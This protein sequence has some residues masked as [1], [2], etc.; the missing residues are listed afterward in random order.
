MH[1]VRTAEIAV[2]PPTAAP[3]S[4]P[5][6]TANP[7]QA[8]AWNGHEGEQWTEHADRYDRAGRR[9]W[10]TLLDRCPVA[11]DD[12]VVDIGCGTGKS[13]RDLA[14]RAHG[15]TVLGVDL[16]A[17]ML[18]LARRRS[19]AEGLGNVTYVQA[20]AQVHPFPQDR[21]DMAISCFGAMF[22]SDPVAAFANIGRGL[23]PGG[24]LV[25][26]AWRDITS[27]EWLTE[28]RSAL[29]VG[30]E[31][32]MPPPEAP[33]PFALADPGRV[34]AILEGS[35]YAGV[36]MEP[37]DEPI[38]FGRDA[39]D[40]Y[41]FMRTLG[42]VKGLTHDLDDRSR[43]EAFAVL[44]RTIAA[45]ETADGVLFGTASWLITAERPGVRQPMTP[46]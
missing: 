36:E 45:H 46:G 9:H 17:P 37:V 13:T 8:A 32:P 41:G 5:I 33:T 38:E 26:L 18:E 29:A 16:S 27:N 31:L 1:E 14:R 24:R 30:R 19:E 12:H 11:P 44:R 21:F 7:D 6:A 42:I 20:D 25:L 3:A 34:R 2:D 40:A 4:P 43:A 28:L 39:E 23:R 22:F 15:G 35:G 10:Q